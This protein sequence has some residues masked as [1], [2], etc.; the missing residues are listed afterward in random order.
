MYSVLAFLPDVVSSAEYT[1]TVPIFPVIFGIGITAL[2]VAS[3]AA[4]SESRE[5][6]Q[7]RAFKA[8]QALAAADHEK[9]KR[10]LEASIA[11]RVDNQRRERERRVA[12]TEAELTE[13][14]PYPWR[15]AYDRIYELDTYPAGRLW[16][17]EWL[18]NHVLLPTLTIEAIEKLV[19]GLVDTDD[20]AQND[21][22]EA[23]LKDLRPYLDEHN[24]GEVGRSQTRRLDVPQRDEFAELRD[25]LP[26]VWYDFFMELRNYPSP[27]SL[28]LKKI[29]WGGGANTPRHPA[30]EVPLT[31]EA[32]KLLAEALGEGETEI[33]FY[34]SDL[35]RFIKMRTERVE[36]RP[37]ILREDDECKGGCWWCPSSNCRDCSYYYPG[38]DNDKHHS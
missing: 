9:Q 32:A 30:C 19:D 21:Q 14:F 13:L 1:F 20:K 8:G 5:S 29:G 33:G 3:F 25:A 11:Q 28:F 26:R 17:S 4:I 16:L 23:I 15:D 27:R 6:A 12:E 35:V 31:T 34:A 38:D 24:E 7:Q 18:R 10:E 22:H 2:A 37:R 36:E